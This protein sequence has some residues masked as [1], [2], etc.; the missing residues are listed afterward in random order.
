ML[1][2]AVLALGVV[3]GLLGGAQLVKPFA[4]QV[5][6]LSDS[7]APFGCHAEGPAFAE[8]W[9]R[10]SLAVAAGLGVAAAPARW[11]VRG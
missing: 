7:G 6:F 3:G 9:W 5:C 1:A 10:W 2:G 8:H 4:T 11:A